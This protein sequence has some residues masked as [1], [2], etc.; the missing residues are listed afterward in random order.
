MTELVKEYETKPFK[1]P[2]SVA[3]DSA[4]NIFFLD[5]G[6]LGET[7][8]SDPKGSAFQITA[9]AQLLQPLALE[10]LAHPCALALSP[11]QHTI[12]IAEMMANRL[13]R[14]VQRAGVF[15]S[16]VFYQFSGRIGPSGIACC[17][18]SGNLYVT[19]YDFATTGVKGLVSVLSPDGKL[20]REITAPAP[21]LTGIALNLEGNA[22][23]VTEESTSSVFTCSV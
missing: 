5:S 6:P 12:Y 10:C 17:S 15:H 11:D 9:D 8:L 19:H 2:S 14:L 3:V 21:E 23:F 13:L 16:S 20:V 18:T 1:G 7:T 4:G 22:I